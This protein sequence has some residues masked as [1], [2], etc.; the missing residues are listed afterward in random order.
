MSAPTPSPGVSVILSLPPSAGLNFRP[1]GRYFHLHARRGGIM[2]RAEDPRRAGRADNGVRWSRS[3]A[4]TRRSFAEPSATAQRRRDLTPGAT[5][6]FRPRRGSRNVRPQQRSISRPAR[7][8]SYAL[9]MSLSR[10]LALGST[11]RYCR[12]RP[13]HRGSPWRLTAGYCGGARKARA[14]VCTRRFRGSRWVAR[15][16]V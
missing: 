4:A 6:F 13:P 11:P 5:H 14:I 10:G 15:R 2:G 16:G 3:G 9:K 12:P 1:A 8:G 7:R